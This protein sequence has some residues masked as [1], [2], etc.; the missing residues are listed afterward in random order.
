MAN[1]TREGDD[2][3]EPA[4]AIFGPKVMIANQMS[5]SGGDALP[6]LFKKAAI[7]PLV[8]VRTWAAWWASADIRSSSTAAR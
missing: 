6:W 4:Q 5:G 8:G 2:V 7:G 3:V 1:V